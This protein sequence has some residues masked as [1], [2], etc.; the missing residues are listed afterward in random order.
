GEEQIQHFGLYDYGY[1]SVLPLQPISVR[2]VSEDPFTLSCY[3]THLPPY[4]LTF[5]EQILNPYAERPTYPNSSHL[6]DRR[7]STYDNVLAA[8]PQPSIP[9]YICR[10]SVKV[11]PFY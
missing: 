6:I 1:T 7:N 11:Q 9:N 10:V 8:N 3:S 4:Q 5:S 2:Y